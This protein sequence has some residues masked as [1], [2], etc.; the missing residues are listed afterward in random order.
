ME[1]SKTSVEYVSR[2]LKSLLRLTRSHSRPKHLTFFDDKTSASLFSSSSLEVLKAEDKI[3]DGASSLA[4]H[5][6]PSSAKAR[7]R[8]DLFCPRIILS[9][10]TFVFS[11]TFPLVIIVVDVDPVANV[12]VVVKIF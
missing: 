12:V 8:S 7:G 6:P 3:V 1:T 10:F 11:F 5:W 9:R 2:A 4:S